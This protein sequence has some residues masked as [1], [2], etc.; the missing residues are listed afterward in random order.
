[1]AQG[2]VDRVLLGADR[3]AANGDVANK[4]GTYA[5]AVLAAH[6]DVPFHVVAPR[7]TFDAATPTGAAIVIEQ[8]GAEEVTSFGG[9][10]GRARRRRGRQ[11]RLRRD[12]RGPGHL[13]HH[14]GRHR[15]RRPSLTGA[16]S[17]RSEPGGEVPCPARHLGKSCRR[18]ARR[19]NSSGR[20]SASVG[21]SSSS[22]GELPRTL[23]VETP[24]VLLPARCPVCHEAGRSPCP[25]CIGRL[26]APAGRGAG[27]LRLRRGR[28]PAARGAEV[29][30]RSQRPALVGAGPG[31]ARAARPVRRGHVGADAR[32]SAP[33]AGLRP[34]RAAG[35]RR[36]RLPRRAVPE[37]APPDR[38][39]R[40]A[41]GAGPGRAA[42][43][44]RRSRRPRRP[45]SP[46]VAGG[47]WSSTT[48]S[49]PAPPCEPRSRRSE[50]AGAVHVVAVAA[51]AT[52][53]PGRPAPAPML[54]GPR[55]KGSAWR[56]A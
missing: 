18:G 24:G 46:P 53:R 7:S 27:G 3:I 43:S 51:A 36:G 56:S 10:T 35:P 20:T 19:V 8:R 4:V 52:P 1:M 23:G 25:G 28:S 16:E 6:H 22:A 15:T 26:V 49:P 11:R 47:C 14:R 30:Q 48:S 9:V 32:R 54:G 2:R 55:R 41:D 44:R 33:A 38:P 39:C 21:S 40:P 12:A 34:G 31:G 45:A 50:A 13:L 37:P 17:E 29:P 42:A 5:L